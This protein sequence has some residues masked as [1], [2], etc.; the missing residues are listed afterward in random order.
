MTFVWS[1][2]NALKHSK[3][4]KLANAFSNTKASGHLLILNIFCQNKGWVEL[5]ALYIV[6]IPYSEKNI[7]FSQSIHQQLP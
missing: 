3:K 4:I 7:I 6:P 1:N 5:A 2:C